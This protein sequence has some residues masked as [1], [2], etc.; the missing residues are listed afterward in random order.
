[1]LFRGLSPEAVKIA[2]YLS[3]CSE[4]GWGG[5]GHYDVEDV[6]TTLKMEPDEVNRLLRQLEALGYV[7]RLPVAGT[8]APPASPTDRLFWDFDPLFKGWNP[9]KDARAVLE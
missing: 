8:D 2:R 1:S 4:T 5:Q 3:D 7:E 9:R 6:A